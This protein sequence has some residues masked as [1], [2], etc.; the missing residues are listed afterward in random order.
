MILLGPRVIF[1]LFAY[2]FD[3]VPFPNDLLNQF[4]WIWAIFGLLYVATFLTQWLFRAP[5]ALELFRSQMRQAL[6]AAE[7]TCL[8]M[9]FGRVHT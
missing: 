2:A 4:G 8:R 6:A 5:T 1:S 9:A 7:L 3:T